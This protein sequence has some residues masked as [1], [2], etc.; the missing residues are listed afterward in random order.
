MR[1]GAWELAI[2][3]A[4]ILILFGVGKL[5]QVMRPLGKGVREAKEAIKGVKKEVDEIKEEINK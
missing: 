5:P 2:I 1:L 3:L 4:I